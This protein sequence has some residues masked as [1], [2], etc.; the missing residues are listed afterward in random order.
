MP[1]T[2]VPSS[3]Y[4]GSFGR[5]VEMIYIQV[6]S[7]DLKL[8]CLTPNYYRIEIL[9]CGQAPRAKKKKSDL[10]GSISKRKKVLF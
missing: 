10:F 4:E 2:F 1:Q 9:V 3:P 6:P 7:I 5:S 8:R